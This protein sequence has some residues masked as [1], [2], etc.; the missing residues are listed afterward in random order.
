MSGIVPC[1]ELSSQGLVEFVDIS[2]ILS[3]SS[4]ILEWD[5]VHTQYEINLS[6][7]LN[8][9]ILHYIKKKIS[10]SVDAGSIIKVFACFSPISLWKKW[11]K[12][13]VLGIKKS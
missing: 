5:N 2:V 1:L 13:S 7:T 3:F 9:D 12:L 11:R 8:Y 10:E 4:P 6:T